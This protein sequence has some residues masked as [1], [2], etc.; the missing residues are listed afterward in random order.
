V[1]NGELTQLYK[2]ILLL[3]CGIFSENEKGKIT[4]EELA[5]LIH[6]MY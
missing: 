1:E 4:K 2:E 6:F 5:K 3:L